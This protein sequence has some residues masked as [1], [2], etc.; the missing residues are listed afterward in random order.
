M[1]NETEAKHITELDFDISR[2]PKQLKDIE[3]LIEQ[4]GKSIRD[5]VD[6]NFVLN[7]SEKNMVAAK[8]VNDAIKKVQQ[9][10]KPL[11]LFNV[12]DITRQIQSVENITKA[13][14]KRIATTILNEQ[15]RSAGAAVR[16]RLKTSEET[17]RANN[18]IYSLERQNQAKLAFENEKLILQA[19]N[20]EYKSG[21]RIAEHK[22]KAEQ[23]T[24]SK[25]LLEV[26]KRN[27]KEYLLEKQLNNKIEV[28]RMKSTDRITEE[29]IKQSN[30]LDAERIKQA[31]K[32][33]AEQIK[34][35]NKLEQIRLKEELK[36]KPKG[37]FEQTFDSVKFAASY[38]AT[39][40]AEQGLRNTLATLKETEFAVM[41]ITRVFGDTTLNVQEFTKSL[42]EVGT[43]YG[44]V[45][46]DAADVT[47]RFA[48]AGYDA[49][50]SLKMTETTM[51]ALN[52]AELN[53][54]E[55]TNNLIGIMQ[56]WNYT[57]EDYSLIVD[58]I[59]KTAD[60]YAITSQDLVNA[61]LK[62]SS[63][64]R[65]AGIDF[66]DLIGIL[67]TL[68]VTS[69]QTGDAVGNAFRSIISYIQRP[70][71]LAG[72][73]GMGIQ[74]YADEAKTKLLPMMQI[75]EN[76]A[77]KWNEMSVAEQ[78]YFMN[79]NAGLTEALDANGEYAK[80]VEEVN[81]LQEEGAEIE[82]INQANFAA[83][84]L[85]RN[86]YISLMENFA[87]VE[88][89]VK[90]LYN[91]EGYS[92][93]ENAK[94]ME[95]L[96]AKYNQFINSLKELAVQAGDAGL[97]DLAKG[98]L[99]LATNLNTLIK[100]VGGLETVL[101]SLLGLMIVFK[102]ES[103][104]EGIASAGKSIKDVGE[105]LY[106]SGLYFKD[107]IVGIKNATGATAK[108]SAATKGL[109]SINLAGWIGIITTALTLLSAGMSAY[110]NRLEEQ[111]KAIIESGEATQEQIKNITKLQHAYNEL[112]SIQERTA[113]QELDMAHAAESVQRAL[114]SKA[115][116]LRELTI[117]TKEYRDEL[118]RLA[119][120]EIGQSLNAMT[121]IKEAA[122]QALI[123][124]TK[125]K[126]LFGFEVFTA[127]IEKVVSSTGELK[128]YEKTVYD[129]LSSFEQISM[130]QST[131][132]SKLFFAPEKNDVQSIVDYY[133][134]L[135]KAQDSMDKHGATLTETERTQLVNSEL[136]KQV[137]LEIQKLS[138]AFNDF[139]NAQITAAAYQRAYESGIPKT[140]E[141]FNSFKKEVIAASGANEQFYEASEKIIYDMFPQFKSGLDD[142]SEAVVIETTF[143][144]RLASAFEETKDAIDG[145]NQAVDELQSAYSTLVAA[146]DE[147]NNTGSLSIDTL[148]TLVA[149]K[150]QYLQLLFNEQGQIQLNE[151][152]FKNLAL[153]EIEEMRVATL[154]KQLDAVS[155]IQS[156]QEALAY[157]AGGYAGAT[158][159]AARL[160]QELERQ[161]SLLVASGKVSQ[162]TA[163]KLASNIASINSLFDKTSKKI[164]SGT[165]FSSI[166]NYRPGGGGGSGGGGKSWYDSQVEAFERLNR[167]GQKNTQEV[168]DFYRAMTQSAKVSAADRL[169]AEEKLFSAIKK[170]IQETKKAQ[171]DALKE[172]KEALKNATD[173]QIKELEAKKDAIEKEAQAELDAINKI[174]KERD[175]AREI[176]DLKE[177]LQSAKDR[178]GKE[179]RKAQYAAEKALKRKQEDYS[180]ED[181]KEQIEANKQAQV[182]AI[183]QE[184]DALKQMSESQAESIDKQIEA[185]NEK[186]TEQAINMLAYSELNSDQ[187]Y[188][189]YVDGFVS[190]MANGM[191]DGFMQATELMSQEAQTNASQLND[192]YSRFFIG[193]TKQEMLSINR[194]LFAIKE[195][196]EILS[197]FPGISGFGTGLGTAISNSVKNQTTQNNNNSRSVTIN[198]R[199]YISEGVD[200]NLFLRKSNRQ[201]TDSI[202]NLP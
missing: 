77:N 152:A 192:I 69:G 88:D 150:P 42:Y 129:I 116:T 73:E 11:E 38:R 164:S 143:Q 6:K 173:E 180:L 156:E 187:L 80:S 34:Q 136:Y 37:F 46:E 29:M 181:R 112:A 5:S 188:N 58:K 174:Q 110:Y 83:G 111:R 170:Q 196:A 33:E 198:N 137:T 195:N 133:T 193:P 99:D 100:D 4:S 12:D 27:N 87:K 122:G 142:V 53:V 40:L 90:N 22:I 59:N 127:G 50:D 175:R 147:W 56:Q 161:I 191:V 120:E 7:F 17:I 72:F 189:A 109:T 95:T 140:V 130:S 75:L 35:A 67:T 26:E 201:L 71:S 158:T 94:Y 21:V 57:A 20:L 89:V 62:S 84:N 52:T 104:S 54:E 177:E 31:N 115:Q 145:L 96:T 92:M 24:N 184:I 179:A 186:Y 13:Q 117:G 10:I 1:P 47:L 172:Q 182:E 106:L 61:L 48:Q 159:E 2:I 131:G 199:N 200:A 15:E 194:E 126:G 157:L 169:K 148:Q 160:N 139:L 190:P 121:S 146:Q 65:N 44:R 149:L 202:L 86:Y 153:A 78:E 91:A 132:A 135:I 185:L 123:S 51:L 141:E 85:R 144:E 167:M 81:R 97:M 82:K 102:R 154:R 28:E 18:K 98:A 134:A 64:A 168:I 63:V 19:Q 119:T 39:Q 32:I 25:I 3:R 49:R 108:L 183:E 103:I 93:R 36:P 138:G 8:D 23:T 66:N 16:E 68:K 45:F 55:A 114:G 41:E 163:N 30:R 14:A 125:D 105:T 176:A 70:S 165:P 107:Y 128:E 166:M 197:R 60:S 178:S 155:A 43:E 9:S 101:K 151:V 124:S 118:E 76:M 171:I 162:D 74:V 113:S 79:S